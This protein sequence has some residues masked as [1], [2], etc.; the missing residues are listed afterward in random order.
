MDREG[1]LGAR[2]VLRGAA[3]RAKLVVA[4][5]LAIAAPATAHA[6]ARAS[7][8]SK[9]AAATNETPRT[10]P[11]AAV[12]AAASAGLT[13][14]VSG[15][16]IVTYSDGSAPCSS[17]YCPTHE[18]PHS[19]V[20]LTATP[21]Q[22]YS[23]ERWTAGCVG[24][25]AICGITP[26][27]APVVSALFVHT[28]AVQLTVSG[29]GRVE[30]DHGAI[31]CGM[32]RTSC[33]GDLSGRGTTDFTVHPASGAFFLGW[34]G[35]CAQF[36]TDSCTVD[37]SAFSGATA[38]FALA[39]PPVGPQPLTVRR[40]GPA[41]SAPAGLDLCL[42]SFTCAT[43]VPSG[44]YYTIYGG[45]IIRERTVHAALAGFLEWRVCW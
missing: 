34:G 35:A 21:A 24:A 12:A 3:A 31:A 10:V 17:S 32:D 9:P 23:F 25:G 28:G 39:S 15:E 42:M 11:F 27:Q 5:A 6:D 22:G 41:A 1:G 38:A 16:G 29:P 19:L 4:L 2:A 8:P 44:S 14:G 43:S 20:F 18:S 7:V 37:N 30:G 13:V 33:S 36:A 26:A 40:D 45:R